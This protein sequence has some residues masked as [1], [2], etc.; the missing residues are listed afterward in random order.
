MALLLLSVLFLRVLWNE[1]REDGMDIKKLKSVYVVSV[2]KLFNQ[3]GDGDRRAFVRGSFVLLELRGIAPS[4]GT[5]HS[6]LD[7]LTKRSWRWGGRPPGMYERGV[8]INQLG[9]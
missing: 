7:S 3:A 6:Y 9:I 2:G 5:I 1:M 8:S 4:T